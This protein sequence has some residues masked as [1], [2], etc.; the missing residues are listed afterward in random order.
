MKLIDLA[1]GEP[2]MTE[3]TPLTR[4]FEQVNFCELIEPIIL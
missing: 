2:A 1:E 4:S 3:E